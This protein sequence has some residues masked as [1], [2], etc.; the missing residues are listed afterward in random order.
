MKVTWESQVRISWIQEG[1]HFIRQQQER[2]FHKKRN[3]SENL[4][5][6]WN[7]TTFTLAIRQLKKNGCKEEVKLERRNM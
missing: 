1:N 4:R 7:F 3:V 5:K 6:E 2:V